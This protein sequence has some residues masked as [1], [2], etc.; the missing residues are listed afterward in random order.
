MQEN[1]FENLDEALRLRLEKVGD[2]AIK[3]ELEKIREEQKR[4]PLVAELQRL[5]KEPT[6][7]R[8]RIAAITKEL[9][10]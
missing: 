6:K 5:Q 7:Y 1:L 2:A 8:A 10:W 3:A 4:E 9:G